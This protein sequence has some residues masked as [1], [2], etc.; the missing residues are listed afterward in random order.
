MIHRKFN[1]LKFTRTYIGGSKQRENELFT[2]VQGAKDDNSECNWLEYRCM[3]KEYCDDKLNILLSWILVAKNLRL[4]FAILGALI[5]G[6]NVVVAIVI[7]A[8]AAVSQGL[9]QHLK[10]LEAKRL[11]EYN[12]SLDVINQ[13]TGLVLAKN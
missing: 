7:L 8:F 13:Q 1:K 6:V 11:T 9:Y 12:F 4:I 10:S 2:E 3:L 5:M